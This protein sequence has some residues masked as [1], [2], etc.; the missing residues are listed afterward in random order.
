MI[1]RLA[2]LLLLV[3]GIGV[4]VTTVAGSQSEAA[5]H[6]TFGWLLTA[7]GVGTF[8]LLRGK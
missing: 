2:A 7:A 5:E 8:A 6:R 3:S 1:G 4:L